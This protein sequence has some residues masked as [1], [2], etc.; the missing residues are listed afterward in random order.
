M[1]EY[2]RY[3]FIIKYKRWDYYHIRGKNDKLISLSDKVVIDIWDRDQTKILQTKS[4]KAPAIAKPGEF[5][6]SNHTRVTSCSSFSAKTL[7]LNFWI[8]AAFPGK[9][10]NKKGGNFQS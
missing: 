9:N 5:L 8:L 2:E 6:L 7:P 4:P 10:K 3:T 1:I